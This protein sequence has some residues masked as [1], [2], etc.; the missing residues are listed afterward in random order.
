MHFGGV[1]IADGL[2]GL[3]SVIAIRRAKVTGSIE[4]AA[5]GFWVHDRP[6]A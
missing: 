6:A 3:V 4:A 5:S 1:P 2:S